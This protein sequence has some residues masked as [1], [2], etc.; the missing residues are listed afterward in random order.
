M[1][2]FK[3]A[4]PT[5]SYIYLYSLASKTHRSLFVTGLIS[6][7][8][9]RTRFMLVELVMAEIDALNTIRKEVERAAQ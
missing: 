5:M 7:R 1:M 3:H 9:V 8:F 2:C 4:L 6:Q